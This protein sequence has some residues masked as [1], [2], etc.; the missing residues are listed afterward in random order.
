[1][2][3]GTTPWRALPRPECVIRVSF[4]TAANGPGVS[5]LALRSAERPDDEAV[6]E[7]RPGKIR[8]SRR[9]ATGPTWNEELPHAADTRHELWLRLWNR[10]LTVCL[11]GARKASIPFVPSA[12]LAWRWE[13]QGGC[14]ALKSPR[15]Q[16]LSEIVMADDF[17]RQEGDELGWERLSGEWAV[18]ASSTPSHAANAFRLFARGAKPA[19]TLAGAS[20]W[21]WS[22]YRFGASCQ[23]AD[24]QA[25]IGLVFYCL[26]STN[27]HLFRWRD[28]TRL[29]LVRVRGA[30]ETVFATADLARLPENWYRL[31]VV[32][33]GDRVAGYVDG[34]RV[35]EAKD[36]ALIG[37]RVGLHVHS[38]RDVWLDDVAVESVTGPLPELLERPF[39]PGETD[40]AMLSHK[41][42]GSDRA[43]STWAGARSSWQEGAEGLHWHT[44]RFWND[45]RLVCRSPRGAVKAGQVAVFAEPGKPDTGYRLRWANGH[46]Q[47][48]EFGREIHVTSIP[49]RGISSLELSASG[50]ELLVTVNEKEL[51][52]RATSA[53]AHSGRVGAAFGRT[54]SR[55]LRGIDWR[56]HARVYS[57]HRVECNFDAAPTPWDAQCG[58]W[59]STNRWAC[60]PQWSFLGGRAADRAI[61]W[62]KRR[63]RGDL[64]LSIAFAPME[65]S[66]QRVHSTFPIVLNVAFCA[67]GRALDSGYNLVFGTNDVPSRLYRREELVASNSERLIPRFRADW[68]RFYRAM[69]R[70]WQRVHIRRRGSMCQISAARF[71]KE[72]REIGMVRLFEYTDPNPLAGERFG[73]WT[74]GQNGMALAR[75]ALSFQESAGPASPSPP[76][77]EPSD[78]EGVRTVTNRASGG[79]LKCTLFS[80]R[81]APRELGTLRF[82]YRL[83]PRTQ[84]GLFVRRRSEIG[85]FSFVG[86]ESYRIGTIPLGRVG[87]IADGA[88]HETLVDLSAAILQAYP[89]DPDRAIDEVFLASPLRT[90]EEI[91]GLGVN[92][93]GTA[94]EIANVKFAA[95]DA[96]PPAR[97]LPPPQVS[98][99]GMKPL[100]DFESALGDWQTFGGQA[101]AML[102]RDPSGARSG[103]YGLRLFNRHVGGPAG[104][105]VTATPFDARLFPRV[106]VDY[107]FPPDLEL[108]LIVRSGSRWYEVA[109]TGLDATWPV[110]GRVPGIQPDGHWHHAQFELASAL[111]GRTPGDGPL[112]VEGLYW[113]DSQ[114]M[115]NIQDLV[116][117]FDNFCRVPLVPSD[118]AAEFA[119]SLRGQQVAAYSY[120]FSAIPNRTPPETATG[121]GDRIQCTVP[122]D[123]KWLHVRA[124]TERGQWSPTTHLPLIV[125]T[126]PV[127]LASRPQ[128]GGPASPRPLAAP[129]V[130]YR[131]SDRLCFYDFDWADEDGLGDEMGPVGIRRG[132][133]ALP[134]HDDGS[135]GNGCVEIVNLYYDDFFSAFLYEGEYDLRRYPRVA[136]DYKFEDPPCVLDITGLLNKEKFLVGWCK[137]DAYEG[138]DP[139]TGVGSISP[140][141]QDKAWHRA[142]LN[143][144]EMIEMIE[145]SGRAKAPCLPLVVEQLNT[146]SITCGPNAAGARL[147]IDNLTIFSPRSRDATFYWQ[148]PG[149]QRDGL[150]Y[151]YGLDHS[152]KTVPSIGPL[153]S[154]TSAQFRNL[155]P[156]QWF[157]HVRAR[158]AEGRWGP[159]SHLRI[160]VR[161]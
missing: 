28:G 151:S 123:A 92:R 103:S 72:G 121:Q 110:T 117:R 44:L 23:S 135:T 141:V 161:E 154:E 38:G 159:A 132:A 124:L 18:Q 86:A 74:W 4:H 58:R 73:V 79:A 152:P 111:R 31:E 19:V 130:S 8:L 10:S 133:W 57:S 126:A 96:K 12:K 153:T 157:F 144:L 32:V 68:N 62:N 118:R 99:Y 107:A 27:F 42:F 149:P 43:M 147:K 83:P 41:A 21:F 11:D 61:L 50:R 125:G 35:L 146:W 1:M 5:R 24:P 15:A 55:R 142:E 138:Y 106:A 69:T 100:D 45:L 52:R 95:S 137:H 22:D 71:D 101:G 70:V 120:E 84:L 87:G 7:I 39:G 104:A 108:N 119:L 128:R 122:K 75:V 47:L 46:L 54:T 134:C 60:E 85:Q 34:R 40:T 97:P 53:L 14:Q 91:A 143:L 16:P 158:D 78:T 131:P 114:R 136:F 116:Y 89:D 59:Q 17:M 94:Y 33:S 56:D 148:M 81:A 51:V 66:T 140:G 13:D 29:E 156:G 67:D 93:L 150:R 63:V 102:W 25:A 26:D 20:Y 155:A 37:G 105:R 127:K 145:S 3:A 160:E 49:A 113:A 129:F 65:A 109:V 48:T 80:G 82:R 30:V 64:D 90:V 2:M 9:G 77:R 112:W 76:I 98:I 139:P 6:L 36:T 115:G 88:W